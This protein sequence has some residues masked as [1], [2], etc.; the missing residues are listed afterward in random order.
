MIIPD[1]VVLQGLIA[2]HFKRPERSWLSRFTGYD[3]TI[4]RYDPTVEEVR[5]V[6]D[7]GFFRRHSIFWVWV[8]GSFLE[9]SWLPS[10]IGCGLRLRPPHPTTSPKKT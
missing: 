2:R 3:P 1:K 7:G 10:L 4:E 8:R 5:P 6:D 9:A